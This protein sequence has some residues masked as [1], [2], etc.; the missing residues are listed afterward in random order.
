[1]RKGEKIL[2]GVLIG[3]AIVNFF[4]QHR[5]AKKIE[6]LKEAIIEKK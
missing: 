1:M 2:I 6:E 3:I 4:L 5:A